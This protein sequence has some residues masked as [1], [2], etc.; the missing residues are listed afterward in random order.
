M[1]AWFQDFMP[2]FF[3]DLKRALNHK[4]SPIFWSMVPL[5]VLPRPPERHVRQPDLTQAVGEQVALMVLVKGLKNWGK[6][7]GRRR[8]ELRTSW[9]RVL[10]LK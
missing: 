7:V 1:F 2:D 10:A 4:I 3:G 8:L 9:L 5:T 6:M